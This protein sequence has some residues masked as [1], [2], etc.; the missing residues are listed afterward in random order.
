MKS[1]NNVLTLSDQEL[2]DFSSQIEHIASILGEGYEPLDAKQTRRM[3]KLYAQRATAAGDIAKLAETFGI[4]AP[5]VSMADMK[6][7]LAAVERLGPLATRVAALHKVLT[8][9]VLIAQSGAW[10]GASTVYGVLQGNAKSNPVLKLALAPVRDQLTTRRKA[11]TEQD[12]QTANAT[13][14]TA[15]TTST[16]QS[17]T[18]ASAKS[19]T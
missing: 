17:A 8:D 13:G 16:A 3:P 9:L 19:A 14:T 10:T 4:S 7:N 11:V 5:G 12:S 1:T 18:T 15:A 6:A 2:S